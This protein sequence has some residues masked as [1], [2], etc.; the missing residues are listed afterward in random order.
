MAF[1][2]K[3]FLIIDRLLLTLT[4]ITAFIHFEEW[5]SRF[6]RCISIFLIW[7][8]FL[9]LNFLRY[10]WGIIITTVVTL[11]LQTKARS[12]I[13][14]IHLPSAGSWFSYC[15][16][17]VY[18]IKVTVRIQVDVRSSFANTRP[19]YAFPCMKETSYYIFA[20][21]IDFFSSQGDII[22][23]VW[24]NGEEYWNCLSLAQTMSL[25]NGC[26]CVL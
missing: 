10:L 20:Q 8:C 9:L 1:T 3:V 24:I 11:L 19:T 16:P 6:F 4:V 21:V 5:K 2:R 13:K 22:F 23:E 18:T 17:V 26:N 25:Q 15:L 7:I 14:Q 12:G